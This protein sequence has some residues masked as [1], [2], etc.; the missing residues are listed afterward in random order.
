MKSE[1]N[2]KW[3]NERS[4]SNLKQTWFPCL[5]TSSL[6]RLPRSGNLWQWF[7]TTSCSASSW[8]FA[9]SARWPSLL[10]DSSSS[11]WGESTNWER[12][13]GKSNDRGRSWGDET[14]PTR[15]C[16]CSLRLFRTQTAVHGVVRG[17]SRFFG[18]SLGGSYLKSLVTKNVFHCLICLF[19]FVVV[20]VQCGFTAAHSGGICECVVVTVM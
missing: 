4:V 6:D 5:F 14:H 10:E 8:P 13:V 7:W 20:V 1:C 11:T 2:H 15:C 9:S 17:L 12:L 19:F 18:L 3:I 16:V